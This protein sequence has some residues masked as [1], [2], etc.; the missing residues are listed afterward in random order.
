MAHNVVN[1][2]MT[3]LNFFMESTYTE[4]CIKAKW[5]PPPT[6]GTPSLIFSFKMD[7]G[8]LVQIFNSLTAFLPPSYHRFMSYAHKYICCTLYFHVDSKFRVHFWR[9]LCDVIKMKD[10]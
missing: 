9:I 2:H 7:E 8:R 4:L 1:V 5:A 3:T 6:K 10:H